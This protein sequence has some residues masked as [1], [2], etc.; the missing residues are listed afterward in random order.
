MY[1]FESIDLKSFLELAE[2]CSD[3]ERTGKNYLISVDRLNSRADS[4]R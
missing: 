4:Y 1:N 3:S 2:I